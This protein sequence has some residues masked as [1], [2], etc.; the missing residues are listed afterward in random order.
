LDE[1]FNKRVIQTEFLGPVL[2]QASIASA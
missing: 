1:T 2:A